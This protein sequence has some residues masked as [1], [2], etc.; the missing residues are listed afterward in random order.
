MAE[1]RWSPVDMVVYHIIYRV[2]TTSQVVFSPDFWTITSTTHFCGEMVLQKQN[3]TKLQRFHPPKKKANY[4][5]EPPKKKKTQIAFTLFAIFSFPFTFIKGFLRNEWFHSITT[6]PGPQE[7]L[8]THSHWESLT[9][10]VGQDPTRA[11]WEA[12]MKES[13][14][15]IFPKIV[16]YPTPQII[17]QKIVFS[18]LNHPF[19]SGY[20][21]HFGGFPLIF[22]GSPI[23]S[24]AEYWEIPKPESH[25]GVIL[26]LKSHVFSPSPLM[27]LRW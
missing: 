21:Y 17:H 14:I 2:S 26:L 27:P 11:T 8:Q 18:I 1:I 13:S 4:R 5:T 22:G 10:H 16:G 3:P 6:S 12:L 20:P 9:V 7:L 15:W 25:F 23:C 19:N 24:W